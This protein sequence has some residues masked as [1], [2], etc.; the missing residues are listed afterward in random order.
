MSI[1]HVACQRSYNDEE[2]KQQI[3]VALGPEQIVSNETSSSVPIPNTPVIDRE[4]PFCPKCNIVMVQ[5]TASRG[6]NKG[7]RFWACPS[8]PE[9]RK[10]IAID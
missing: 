9:C 5:R 3:R 2:L 4:A 6:S 1:L 10:I 8:Y 7:K